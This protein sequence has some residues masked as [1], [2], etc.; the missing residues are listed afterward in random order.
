MTVVLLPLTTVVL[1]FAGPILELF[2]H[3]YATHGTTLLRIFAVGALVDAVTNC[4]VG[5]RNAQHRL[6]EVA[7]LNLTMAVIAIAGAAALLPV[8]GIEAVGW[9]WTT[10]QLVGCLW[11]AVVVLGR[12]SRPGTGADGAAAHESDAR[13]ARAMRLTSTATKTT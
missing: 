7:A 3:E 11:V 12:R 2:G 10:A 6:A 8:W 1:L 9:S 5:I 4:Y 13:D